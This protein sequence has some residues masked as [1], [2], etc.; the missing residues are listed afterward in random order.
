MIFEME[1]CGGCRTCEIACSFHHTDEF[2]PSV[3]SIKIL[4]KEGGTG[5]HVLLLEQDDGKSFA[6]DG[7][8]GLKEPLCMEYCKEKE[9]LEE[10]IRTLLAKR[11]AG[12]D[13]EIAASAP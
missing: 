12:R 6:C 13:S 9:A 1:K 7:C 10:M 2:N 5:Y 11:N 4:D 3:S 8:Q